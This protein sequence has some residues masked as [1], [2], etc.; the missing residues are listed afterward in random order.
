MVEVEVEVEE[1]EV[2]VSTIVERPPWM[3]GRQLPMRTE[4]I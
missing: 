2:V 4:L 3:Q 1:V